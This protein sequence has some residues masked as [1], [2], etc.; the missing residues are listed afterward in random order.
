MLPDAIKDFHVPVNDPALIIAGED[1]DV[2]KSS[3]TIN[4]LGNNYLC[5]AFDDSCGTYLTDTY[6]RSN[7]NWTKIATVSDVSRGLY[8]LCN[9][10][11]TFNAD[12][13]DL[14]KD[15]ELINPA[16]VYAIIDAS[17]AYDIIPIESSELLDIFPINKLD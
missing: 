5:Y 3:G 13:F 16:K 9:G 10:G 1:T 17:G 15:I 7:T 12:T 2:H 8:T 11:I 6:S 14:T 4:I